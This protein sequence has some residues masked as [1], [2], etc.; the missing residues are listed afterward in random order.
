MR[1]AGGGLRARRVRARARRLK[2]RHDIGLVVVDYLQLLHSSSK[3]AQDNRQQ[4]VAELS[5]GV[6]SLVRIASQTT[7][8]MNYRKGLMSFGPLS[9]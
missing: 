1:R 3:K 7:V 8:V 5:S 2:R 9:Q 4:E 6:K